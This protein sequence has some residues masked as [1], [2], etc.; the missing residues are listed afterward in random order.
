MLKVV[1]AASLGTVFEWYDFYLYGSLAAVIAKKFFSGADP[2]AAFLFALL[3]FAAGF[4]VRP[5]GALVFG[6][7]GDLVGRKHTFLVT[8]LIMGGSTLCVG[9]LPGYATIGI[10]APIILVVLRMLQGLALGGEYGGAAT[11]IA[12]HSPRSRRGRNTSWL[13]TTGSVGLLL[14]LVVIL[15]VRALTGDKFD[16]WGWRI[17]F[18][19]SLILLAISTY[20][21]LSM[22]ES[23]AFSKAKQEGNLSKAP[24]KEAFG[25]WANLKIVLI[26]LFGICVGTPVVVYT[27]IFYPIFFLTETLKVDPQTVNG[28]MLSALLVS[29]LFFWSFGTLSDYIGRKPVILCGYI[30][31]ATTFFPIFKGITHFANPALAHAQRVSPITVHTDTTRCS[32][33]FNPT[34]T[35]TF[36]TPCD[37]ARR[38]LSISSAS[39]ATEALPVGSPTWISIGNER[40]EVYDATTFSGDELK[41]VDGEFKHSIRAGLDAAGYPH[42]ADPKSFNWLAVF[43]LLLLLMVY[44]GMVYGPGAAVLV[45]MFPTRIRYTGLSVPYHVANGWIGGLLPTCAFALV[46]QTGNI[47]FGLW[48]PVCW[49]VVAAVALILFY[50]ESRLND[51]NV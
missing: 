15:T 27:A 20:I 48:Y 29:P 40:F 45:E 9:L 38:T 36:T 51:I 10:A 50:R 1:A 21:R 13:Q 33:Q 26:A 30:L 43:G 25:R 42:T 31:A 34:G 19:F 2:S 24:V 4:L 18:L 11:Y 46:A 41:R 14:S 5:F 28:V 7:L 16:D 8:I 23:P 22:K 6:R 12:E 44:Q 32:F 39:Y 35:R 37:I 17:P 3:A 47:Y 49:I